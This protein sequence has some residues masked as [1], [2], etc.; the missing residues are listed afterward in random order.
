MLI[1]G[2]LGT[3]REKEHRKGQ[4]INIALERELFLAKVAKETSCTKA[5]PI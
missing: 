1:G 4:R 5:C 2:W 3:V